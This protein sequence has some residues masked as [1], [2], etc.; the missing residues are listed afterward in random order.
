ME[1]DF[2]TRLKSAREATDAALA[3]AMT[4]RAGPHSWPERLREA[5]RYALLG[6]GKRLRPFL[7]IETA[8]IFG[9]T[10]DGVVRAA[11]ALECIH[12]YSLVHDDLPAMDDD[13]LRRGRPTVHKAYDEATAILVGDALQT[14]AF[15]VLADAATDSDAEVRLAL[16][17]GLAAASGAGGMAGGQ[18]LDIAAERRMLRL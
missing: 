2:E 9:Q 13:D 17:A 11:A 3:R 5:M 12:C 16:I 1:S 18:M 6:P 14:L 10:G 4:A 15:S 7:V 8:R